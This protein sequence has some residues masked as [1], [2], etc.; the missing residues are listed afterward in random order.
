MPHDAALIPTLVAGLGAAFV[1]GLLAARLRLP[2]IVGYLVAG[3]VVGPFSPGFVADE[4]L[5]GQL[6]ELGVI[7]LMFG[8]GLHF[9]IEDLIAV[10]R[11]VVR[12]ALGQ[13][14]VTGTIGAT[15]ALMWGWGAGGALVLA[16]SLGVAST[17]VLLKGLEA[18]D[19][20]DSPEGRLAVGWLVVEDLAMV[21]AL[22][23]LPA[24]APLLR[25]G[26]ES[27]SAMALAMP[28]A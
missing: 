7:L 19:R 22:V 24:L 1:L 12:G 11:T 4:A 18:S 25:G 14:A 23:L 5:T 26:V 6:A 15:L 20:L 10:R 28:V 9:S 17:V 16:L 21:L 3:I 2:P 8:V 27:I 13:I